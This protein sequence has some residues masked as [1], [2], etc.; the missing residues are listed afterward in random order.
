MGRENKLKKGNTATF[1]LEMF[2]YSKRPRN[3]VGIR[4]LAFSKWATGWKNKSSLGNF[5]CSLSCNFVAWCNLPSAEMNT[6]R[7][8]FVAVTVARSRTDFYFLQQ[9]RQ[10]VHFRACYTRQRL[11][12][13]VSQQDCETNCKKNWLV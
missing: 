3:L 7:N 6:P 10:Q 2:C 9:L 11:V 13:L 8:V 1:R 12:Q 4:S 5:S